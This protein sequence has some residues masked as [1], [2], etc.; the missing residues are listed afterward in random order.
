MKAMTISNFGDS[1][2]FKRTD[3]P[4]PTIQSGQ[5]LI[6]VAAS[7]VNPIDVKIRSGL[8][9]AISPSFPAILNVDVAGEVMEIGSDVEN[10]AIGD[11]VLALGGGVKGHDG[12]LAEFM[13]A[14]QELIAPIPND[15]SYEVAASLPVIGLTAYEAI[16]IRGQ[17]QPG[18]KVLVHGGAGGVG[19]IGVQL[20]IA[21]GAEVTTTVGNAEQAT[22]VEKLGA[23]NIIMYKETTVEKY[24]EAYTDGRGFDVVLDPVGAINLANSFK[25]SRIGG[26]ITTTNARSTLDIHDMHAKGLTLHALFILIPLL[27]GLNKPMIG[28]YLSELMRMVDN[29]ELYPVLHSRRYGFS[30]ISEAHTLLEQKGNLGK[31]CLFNDL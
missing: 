27:Y 16:K 26:I 29:G 18:Q 13:R 14:D 9:P 4:K 25:A 1:S 19:H 7:S 22:M 10:Y 31:I 24:V 20:A 15:I 8:V 21:S 17:V 6:K 2:V 11:R 28:N 3:L 30:E 5:V 12:S 23:H